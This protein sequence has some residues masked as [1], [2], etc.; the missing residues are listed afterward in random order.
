ML[1]DADFDN[2]TGFEG[3]DYQLGLSWDNKTQTWSRSLNSYPAYGDQVTIEKSI[4]AF[5]PRN[6]DLSLDLHSIRHGNKYQV[7]FYA[8]SKKDDN[9]DTIYDFTRWLDFPPL[10]ITISTSAPSV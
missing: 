1:I 10:G 6:G 2:S 3:F 8:D 5:P 4:Y 9:S 7:V